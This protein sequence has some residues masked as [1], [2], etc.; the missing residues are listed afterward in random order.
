MMALWR[1]VTGDWRTGT[2]SRNAGIVV[3]EHRDGAYVSARD[4]DDA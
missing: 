3:V 4:G 2:V 1:H